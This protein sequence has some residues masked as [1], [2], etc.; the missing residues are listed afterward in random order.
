MTAS[1]NIDQGFWSANKLLI[2]Q[3][4]ENSKTMTAKKVIR[5][6]L[7]F[8]LMFASS[9]WNSRSSCPY[10]CGVLGYFHISA[11][12]FLQNAFFSVSVLNVSAS[13]GLSCCPHLLHVFVAVGILFIW[14][15]ISSHCW[16]KIITLVLR[17]SML[18]SSSWE[19]AF[20]M[21]LL[22]FL[23]FS[24]SSFNPFMCVV[25]L[26]VAILLIFC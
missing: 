15:L 12:Q 6:V 23:R 20:L 25:E 21:C 13:F 1:T 11:K 5:F 8:I 16:R 14:V 4:M 9:I 10:K 17:D 3:N 26:R 2:P 22:W 18:C 19:F 24:K 7:C